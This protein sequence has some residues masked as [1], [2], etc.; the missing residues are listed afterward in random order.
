MTTDAETPY[1]KIFR[2]SSTDND[3]SGVVTQLE[4]GVNQWLQEKLPPGSVV[5]VQTQ[6]HYLNEQYYGIATVTV[7]PPSGASSG[8]PMGFR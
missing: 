5:S 8:N 4:Q 1:I 2:S 7:L 3:P 6:L